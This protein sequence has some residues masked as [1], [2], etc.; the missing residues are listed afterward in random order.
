MWRGGQDVKMGVETKR[1]GAV[2][3]GYGYFTVHLEG[4]R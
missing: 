3:R 2:S 4:G 1:W